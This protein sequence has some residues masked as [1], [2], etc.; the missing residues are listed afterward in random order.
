MVKTMRQNSLRLLASKLVVCERRRDCDYKHGRGKLDRAAERYPRRLRRLLGQVEAVATERSSN[1]GAVRCARRW[2]IGGGSRPRGVDGGRRGFDVVHGAVRW[3]NF[4]CQT[5][6]DGHAAERMFLIRG[7]VAG[8]TWGIRARGRK[9][10][11][12]LAIGEG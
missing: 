6:Q 11:G 12:E 10:S 4:F 5:G 1:T 7:L 8:G 9:S 3:I 2:V